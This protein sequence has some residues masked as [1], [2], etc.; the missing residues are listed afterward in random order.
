MSSQCCLLSMIH[1]APN[2][3][4]AEN[5]RAA[6]RNNW[7]M[8]YE[9][10]ET[11]VFPQAGATPSIHHL[12]S[13]QLSKTFLKR[14]AGSEE[15][16]SG[17]AGMVF[18]GSG[19]PQLL[20]VCNPSTYT[21]M[22]F[23]FDSVTEAFEVFGCTVEDSSDFVEYQFTVTETGVAYSAHQNSDLIFADV[24]NPGTYTISV[25]VCSFLNGLCNL[26]TISATLEVHR[27]ERRLLPFGF[28]YSDS[29]LD[30]A[31]DRA[32]AVIVPNGIP[33][34]DTYHSTI[35]VGCYISIRHSHCPQCLG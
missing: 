5:T 12:I 2:A 29:S 8:P 24:V 11:N 34:W 13:E 20:P 1:I 22:A 9:D 33:F 19:S 6:K 17:D 35:Y 18:S 27:H 26:M 28:T 7:L 10:T 25:S 21:V 31:D 4:I 14:Q 15:A 32:V 23:L 16:G 30:N 3:A